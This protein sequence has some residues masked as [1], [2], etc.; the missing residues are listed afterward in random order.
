MAI[1]IFIQPRKRD[2]TLWG[3]QWARSGRHEKEQRGTKEDKRLSVKL[4]A[5]GFMWKFSSNFSVKDCQNS[6]K[7]RYGIVKE[8]QG[9]TQ[10]RLGSLKDR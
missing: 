1:K 8:R 9:S 3:E 5:E 10:D 2:R 7:V 6:L 4:L